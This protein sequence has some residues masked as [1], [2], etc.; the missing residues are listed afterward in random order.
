MDKPHMVKQ[1]ITYSD[2]TETVINYRGKFVDGVLVPDKP[3]VVE[4]KEEET[5]ELPEVEETEEVEKV[6]E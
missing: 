1:T 4:E 5:I 6:S 2:G 3:E